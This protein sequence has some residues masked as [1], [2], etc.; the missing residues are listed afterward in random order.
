MSP[1]CTGALSMRLIKDWLLV[2]RSAFALVILPFVVLVG[3]VGLV[4]IIGFSALA[5]GVS[6]S[7]Q[8]CHKSPSSK[9]V[10]KKPTK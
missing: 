4:A 10:A 6:T 5:L 1:T 9:C 3:A 7:V 8:D 2:I